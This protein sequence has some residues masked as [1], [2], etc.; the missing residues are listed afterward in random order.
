LRSGDLKKKNRV[1]ES[2]QLGV[3]LALSGGLMDAYT[4]V[5]RGHVFA[6]A[7][8]GN[9]LLLGVSLSEGN[10]KTAMLYLYPVLAFSFGVTMSEIVKHRYWY[11]RK[12][13]WMQ[14]TIILEAVILLIV[15]FLPQAMNTLA[16]CM[17]SFACGVQVQSFRTIKGNGIATTMCIGNLRTAT[18]Y[19][20]DYFYDKDR[21][22]LRK[23][24]MYYGIILIFVSGAIIGYKLVQLL[25][26]KA[27]IVSSFLMMIGFL[28]LFL[29]NKTEENG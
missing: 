19:I 6:N 11:A 22:L 25:A 28:M 18:Q 16:N 20:S 7:Q 29:E 2:I 8:T 12:L 24:L 4:Y 3:I 17:V 5:C 13:H 21:G 15:G 10:F 27:I 26:E 23:G 9:I 14:I 1:S